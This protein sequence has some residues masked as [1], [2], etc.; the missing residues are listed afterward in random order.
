MDQDLFT[1][2]WMYGAI[3]LAPLGGLMGAYVVDRKARDIGRTNPNGTY[4]GGWACFFV[5][6]FWPFSVATVVVGAAGVTILH[7]AFCAV[8]Y[9]FRAFRALMDRWLGSVE[10]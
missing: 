2:I 3:V 10:G 8:L 9:I 1:K 6:L 4:F 5:G 7:L